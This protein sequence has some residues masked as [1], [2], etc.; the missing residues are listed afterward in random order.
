MTYVETPGGSVPYYTEYCIRY[1][2]TDQELKDYNLLHGSS[3]RVYMQAE[4]ANDAISATHKAT[5]V[6]KT[7]INMEAHKNILAKVKSSPT[8]TQKLGGSDMHIILKNPDVE[9]Q[10]LQI[11][12]LAAGSSNYKFYNSSR[13]VGEMEFSV[14][15]NNLAI[16][17]DVCTYSAPN[18]SCISN[19][20]IVKPY[21]VTVYQSESF[22]YTLHNWYSVID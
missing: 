4:F 15:S 17:N 6:S 8:I 18:G 1:T 7:K 21:N 13:Y 16:E 2:L 3:G 19:G 11:Y 10:T 9:N 22:G 20:F 5:I 12:I 14:P